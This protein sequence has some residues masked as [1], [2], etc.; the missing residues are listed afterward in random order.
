ME[1]AKV[2]GME[3]T[4]ITEASKVWDTELGNMVLPSSLGNHSASIPPPQ[5]TGVLEYEMGEDDEDSDDSDDDDDDG[6]CIPIL[7]ISNTHLTCHRCCVRIRRSR[8]R[9]IEATLW[10]GW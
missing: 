8:R 6:K 9:N 3:S 5:N 4:G 2:L 7:N 10:L 1:I